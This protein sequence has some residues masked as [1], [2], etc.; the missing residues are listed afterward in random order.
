M[1]PLPPRGA[2]AAL[3]AVLL[4]ALAFAG[5]RLAGLRERGAPPVPAGAP[6]AVPGRGEVVRGSPDAPGPLERIAAERD[7]ALAAVSRLEARLAEARRTA[8]RDADD[9]A[10]YRRIESGV[11]PD[12]L[13]IGSVALVGADTPR[14]AL[15]V[16]LVQS[17]GRHRVTGS[18]RARVAAG[19]PGA[20]ATLGPGPSAFDLR[21]FQ[22]VRVPLGEAADA[23]GREPAPARVELD[24][25]PAGERHERFVETVEIRATA[26]NVTVRSGE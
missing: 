8:A 7:A 15:A 26:P 16:T 11:A 4:L 19:E 1:I 25:R 2:L 22:R 24:V 6:D 9:L 20:G 14:A 18:V 23:F 17:R 5:G 13:S 21:F 3:A 12:G 10:L